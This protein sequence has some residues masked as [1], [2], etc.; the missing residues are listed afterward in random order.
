VVP[1]LEAVRDE[2][3]QHRRAL[4]HAGERLAVHV[5]S[6][7]RL[8]A[9]VLPGER[10]HDPDRGVRLDRPVGT[11][12]ELLFGRVVEREDHRRLAGRDVELSQNEVLGANRDV[13]LAVQAR[14]LGAELGCRE[15][16]VAAVRTD[17]VVHQDRHET[18]FVRLHLPRCRAEVRRG[19]RRLQL[20]D[21]GRGRG[22]RV[23]PAAA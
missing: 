12:E 16:V 13:V 6:A 18:E 21:D 19:N 1:D 11:V 5:E 23:A 14:E 15:V 8:E 17:L 3:A 2:P 20:Q 10:E 22:T 4:A 7:R 9:G